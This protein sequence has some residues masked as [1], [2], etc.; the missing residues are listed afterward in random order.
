MLAY[1]EKAVESWVYMPKLHTPTFSEV[2]DDWL[3]DN[4]FRYA[5]VTER[6]RS[7]KFNSLRSLPF[8]P[9]PMAEG[10]ALR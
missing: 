7:F 9:E 4:N 1:I 2:A 8:G 5:L 10:Q 3:K 6:H